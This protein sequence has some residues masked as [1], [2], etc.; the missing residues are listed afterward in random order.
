MNPNSWNLLHPRQALSTSTSLLGY[1]ANKY[2]YLSR[3]VS[4]SSHE[5]SSGEW[6]LLH[7]TLTIGIH[8]RHNS[9]SFLSMIFMGT[10]SHDKF[11]RKGIVS[12]SNTCKGS[13]TYFCNADTWKTLCTSDRCGGNAKR[14]AKRPTQSKIL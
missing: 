2:G 11:S 3:I 4:S 8:L 1:L 13:A 7:I 10:S 9:F 6:W 5:A 14:Y 12:T